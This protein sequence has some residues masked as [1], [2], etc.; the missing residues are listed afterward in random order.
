MVAVKAKIDVKKMMEAGI[1]LGH[2][3]SK[4]HPHMEDFVLGIRNTV[5]VIDLEKAAE[6]LKK[7]LEFVEKT[8]KDKGT[9]LFVNT[10]LPSRRLVKETARECSMPYVVERWLGGTFTNFMKNFIS[11][12]DIS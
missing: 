12:Y 5:H 3:T 11:N 1:H 2:R 9:I 6:Y 10:K 7:A 4:L 8:V